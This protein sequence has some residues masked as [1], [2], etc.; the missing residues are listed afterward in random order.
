MPN[1]WAQTWL[2]LGVNIAPDD[3]LVTI[4]SAYTAPG[5]FYHNLVHVID[6]LDK[7]DRCVVAPERKAEI[8]LALWFHDA[9]Y[10]TRASASE[11]RSAM[12]A[13]SVMKEQGVADEV[14]QRIG[15]LILATAHKVQ[16]RTEDQRLICDIDLSIL[17]EDAERF[18]QYD[19]QIRREYAWV[20]EEIYRRK[21]AEVMT[22][23]LRR[24]RLYHTDEFH[25]HYDVAARINLRALL[26]ELDG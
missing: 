13:R 21:R 7:L 5:R 17:G 25:E 4:T 22:G 15:D 6:C 1:R 2:N 18:R 16:P 12:L 14:S 11:S 24:P 8:E 19:R 23:F 26:D 20:P 10:D 3:V 9:V